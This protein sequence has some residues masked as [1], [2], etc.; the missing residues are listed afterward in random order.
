[1]SELLVK[2]LNERF[3]RRKTVTHVSLASRPKLS[4][5]TDDNIVIATAGSGKARFWVT[6]DYDL[7]DIPGSEQ[8]RFRL[9]IVTP[10]DLLARIRKE[11]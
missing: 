4:G 8:A 2:R 1:M 6:N 5:D 7:S 11:A 3:E 10:A 9:L